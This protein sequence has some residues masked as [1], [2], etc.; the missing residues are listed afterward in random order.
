MN[1]LPRRI[2]V[3]ANTSRLW[4]RAKLRSASFARTENS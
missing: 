2:S 3:E 4:R 1:G